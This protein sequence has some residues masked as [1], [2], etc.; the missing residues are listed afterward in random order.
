MTR[1]ENHERS[2]ENNCNESDVEGPSSTA[3]EAT[4]YVLYVEEDS[5][6]VGDGSCTMRERV[7]GTGELVSAEVELFE[8]EDLEAEEDNTWGEDAERGNR[9]IRANTVENRS[10]RSVTEVTNMTEEVTA[11]RKAAGKPNY[12]MMT[13]GAFI[14]GDGRATFPRRHHSPKRM[15][16]CI[17]F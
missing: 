17:S 12:F 6:E 10:S 3:G 15:R 1:E 7:D 2:S 4:A 11:R 9:E 14:T 13:S 8:C 16:K 5:G